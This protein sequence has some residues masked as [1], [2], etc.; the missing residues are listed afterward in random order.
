MD[1]LQRDVD[2]IKRFL[3]SQGAIP[4]GAL[5]EAGRTYFSDDYTGSFGSLQA[6]IANITTL[7]TDLGAVAKKGIYAQLVGTGIDCATGLILDIRLTPQFY[8]Y[9]LTNIFARATT[10]GTTGSMTVSIEQWISGWVEMCSTLPTIASGANNDNGSYVI[11]TD[12]DTIPATVGFLRVSIDAIHT[13]PAKGLSL[14]L[15][16]ELP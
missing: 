2:W 7:N 11:D 10:A 6:V 3:V 5:G 9:K 4:P 15:E 1:S 8:G 16:F 12:Y 13:T 14:S